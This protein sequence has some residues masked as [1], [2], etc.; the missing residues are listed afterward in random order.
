MWYATS[1]I[2]FVSDGLSKLFPY[3]VV[4]VDFWMLVSVCLTFQISF[5][6]D[7]WS[8]V[9][10]YVFYSVVMTNQPLKFSKLSHDNKSTKA[11][12]MVIVQE[13]SKPQTAS[14]S[15]QTSSHNVD[16]H[17]STWMDQLRNQLNFKTTK[18]I[19]LTVYSLPKVLIFLN[20]LLL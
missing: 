13:D 9:L 7:M 8:W 10:Q 6:C 1:C 17:V 15:T 14:S 19:S 18:A 4:L 11:V 20:S 2:L 3:F 16:H 12:N 5:E